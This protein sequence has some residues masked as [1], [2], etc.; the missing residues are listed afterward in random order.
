MIIVNNIEYKTLNDE[1]FVNGKKVYEVYVNNVKVYPDG[2]SLDGWIQ[3]GDVSTVTEL[4]PLE[5]SGS[6]MIL[7]ATGIGSSQTASLGHGQEGSRIETEI[8]FSSRVSTVTFTYDFISEEPMEYV[9]SRY[10]DRL[11]IGIRNSTDEYEVDLESINSSSWISI[12][13]IDFPGGDSTT[14]HTGWKT[15]N[16]DV[17]NF[18]S[19]HRSLDDP[20]YVYITVYDL[21]DSAYDTAALIREISF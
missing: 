5:N 13:G 11:S 14:F 4:G 17:S 16:F 15:Y 7:V 6:E 8:P 9:G 1:L 10:D 20:I 18:I 3:Y 21:G 12:D 19:M 2:V